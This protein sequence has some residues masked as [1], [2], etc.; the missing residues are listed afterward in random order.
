MIVYKIT[1]DIL[2]S[3]KLAGVNKIIKLFMPKRFLIK[4]EEKNYIK[5]HNL[6]NW[7]ERY[8]CLG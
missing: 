3:L 5:V 4:K 2:S 6:N 7:E 8:S 1:F